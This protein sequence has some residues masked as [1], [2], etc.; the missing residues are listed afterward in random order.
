MRQ[1]QKQ[2]NLN[3][4]NKV[5]TL[6]GWR[7]PFLY[8][9]YGITPEEFNKKSALQ[10][11]VCMICKQPQKTGIKKFLSIDHNH[12]TGELRDLLCDPC[13]RAMGLMKESIPLLQNM[14][15]YLEIWKTRSSAEAGWPDRAPKGYRLKVKNV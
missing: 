8:T 11:N 10:D 12:L 6:G 14:I 5:M 15:A 1:N 2:Y 9:N 13:N 3:R 7:V 4:K